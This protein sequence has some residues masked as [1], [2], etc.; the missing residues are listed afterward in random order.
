MIPARPGF[1]DNVNGVPPG[2]VGVAGQFGATEK[3]PAFFIEGLD[4]GAQ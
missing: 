3:T 4:S 2:E 1:A